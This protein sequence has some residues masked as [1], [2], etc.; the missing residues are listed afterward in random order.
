[1]SLRE[2]ETSKLG[3]QGRSSCLGVSARPGVVLHGLVLTS[4]HDA[5]VPVVM[6]LLAQWWFASCSMR[7]ELVVAF[8]II[9]CSLGDIVASVRGVGSYSQAIN[10]LAGCDAGG[11]SPSLVLDN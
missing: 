3:L 1:M 2:G 10:H 6:A 7:R 5:I 11:Q 9:S 4:W 8:I